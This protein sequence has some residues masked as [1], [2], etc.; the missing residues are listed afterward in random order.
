MAGADIRK[1]ST[2]PDTTIIKQG[3][4]TNGKFGSDP[5]AKVRG[6]NAVRDLNPPSTGR[7]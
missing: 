7:R 3:H 6:G 1:V 4:T 2:S 5:M